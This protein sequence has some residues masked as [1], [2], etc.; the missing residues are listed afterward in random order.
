MLEAMGADLTYANEREVGGEPVAD[1]TARYSALT[2]INVPADVA[3]SMIDEFPVFFIAASMAS[4]RT[5][6][7]GLEELRVKESDRLALMATGLKAIGATV[8]ERD[9][10]L[11]I[12]GSGGEPLEGG[13]VVNSAFDHRLA[14]SFAVAGQHCYHGVTVDDVSPIAT[15]FPTFE[16]MLA[17]LARQIG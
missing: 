11:I 8:E 6:T 10:G 14:M 13:A 17:D 16:A 12:D 15:S 9:D 7:S 1:I 2:G 4:G 3:P 5:V